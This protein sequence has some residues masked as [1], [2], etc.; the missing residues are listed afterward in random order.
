MR[1]L[2][3]A[4]AAALLTILWALP[5]GAQ[6]WTPSGDAV[7]VS[8]GPAS[9]NTQ[10][11]WVITGDLAPPVALICNNGTVPAYIA[12]GGPNLVVTARRP[13]EF[14]TTLG[15]LIPPKGCRTLRISGSTNIAAI[16][17][18]GTTSLA[19]QAGIGTPI[20]SIATAPPSSALTWGGI[21][22][23]WGGVAI[24]GL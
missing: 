21:A 8:A 19:V 17:P 2:A 7:S 6:D 16:A 1:S 18:G 3:C 14:G 24:T 12:L 9:S 5:V 10:L 23:T 22:L 13:P 20:G 15:T 11:G 4:G